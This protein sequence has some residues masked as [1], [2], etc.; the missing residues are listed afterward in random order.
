VSII[1]TYLLK[2]PDW[3]SPV[4]VLKS[5]RT[6]VQKS[7]QSAEKRGRIY[8]RARIGIRFILRAADYAEAAYI[9]R[10]VY[11][12]Q[13]GIVGIPLWPYLARIE[14][15]ASAGQKDVQVESTVNTFFTPGRTVVLM[16]PANPENYESGVIASVIATVITLENNLDNTWDAGDEIVPVIPCRIGDS[17]S[18][19]WA[20]D[21]N[22]SISIEAR[23]AIAD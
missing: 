12:Y 6:G 13:G 4:K 9:H 21:R 15:Q 20:T 5:W 17:N 16:D 2:K 1:N 14:A 3:S 11:K 22:L 8:S 19:T 10:K 7:I 23:E 18:F